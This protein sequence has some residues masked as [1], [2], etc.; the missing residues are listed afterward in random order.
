LGDIVGAFKS[1][2]THTYIQGVNQRGWPEFRGR[3]WQRNYY[4]HIIRDDPSMQRIRYYIETNPEQWAA[5]R[6]N[7]DAA[8][9]IKGP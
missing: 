5:D 3:V 8:T 7:P 2:T 9:P 4:E 6:E 1:I